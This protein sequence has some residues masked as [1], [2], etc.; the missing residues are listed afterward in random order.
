MEVVRKN[1]FEFHFPSH[2]DGAM[3]ACRFD[4]EEPLTVMI[5]DDH[6]WCLLAGFQL[7]AE[8]VHGLTVDDA[9]AVVRVVDVQNSA[10]GHET[11]KK[12]L[13]NTFDEF[14]LPAR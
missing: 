12:V 10:V 9:H 6:V 8:F 1:A 5:P 11:W 2:I 3:S 14:I 4:Q 7:D 13:N